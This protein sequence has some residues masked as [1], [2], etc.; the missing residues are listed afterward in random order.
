MIISEEY[1]ICILQADIHPTDKQKNFETYNHLLA[2][3]TQQ[4]DLILFPEMFACGFSEQ[5]PILSEQES[6]ES[7]SYLKNI[8]KQYN[9]SVLGTIA[10]KQ[11]RKLF[12]RLFCVNRGEVILRYDKHHLFFGIEKKSFEKGDCRKYY[13]DKCWNILPLICY[14]MRFP[15]WCSNSLT[16]DHEKPLYDILVF[17][18]N[19]PSSRY[20]SF[21]TLIK[22]RAIENQAYVVAINR[23]G[24]D[25]YGVSHNGQSQIISPTGR[26]LAQLPK[27]SQNILEFSLQRSHLDEYRQLFPVFKDW[28]EEKID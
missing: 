25:G 23:I 15:I 16:Q 8:S 24:K 9:C 13:M 4:P 7:L 21:E 19:F 11:E 28:N 5:L 10:I 22:A 26:V 20:H 12:N 14:D 27:N 17:T 6:E 1:R 2:N 3:M 18:T